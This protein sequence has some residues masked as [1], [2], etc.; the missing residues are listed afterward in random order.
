ML[1]QVVTCLYADI[2]QG[3]DADA[4]PQSS[5]ASLVSSTILCS[6]LGDRRIKSQH[7]DPVPFSNASQDLGVVLPENRRRI[8]SLHDSVYPRTV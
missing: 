5:S 3:L 4:P 6:T 7:L 2:P 8:E 1:P